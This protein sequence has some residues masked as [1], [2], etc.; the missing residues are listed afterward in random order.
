MNKSK[1]IPK[2]ILDFV[3]SFL[4]ENSSFKSKI[5]NQQIDLAVQKFIKAKPLQDSHIRKIV[6]TIRMNY[7]FV[8][9][10]DETG[11]L[12]ADGDGYYVS[13]NAQHIL[14]H[15]QQYKGRI[16]KMIMIHSKCVTLLTGKLYTIQGKL[17]F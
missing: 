16:N 3:F 5:T 15:A 10:H 12:C 2:G 6:W 17:D 8:N 9:E 7:H 13:Y 11:W 14:K 4:C 1:N